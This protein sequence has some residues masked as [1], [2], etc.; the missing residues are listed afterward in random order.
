MLGSQAWEEPPLERAI[1]PLC[2]P[3]ETQLMSYRCV[4][5]SWLQ[6]PAGQSRQEQ[7]QDMDQDTLGRAV[8]SPVH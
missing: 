6:E 3:G 5:V 1:C 4:P 8:T 2:H 7:G